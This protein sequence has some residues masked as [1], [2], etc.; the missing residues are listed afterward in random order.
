MKTVT[1][2]IEPTDEH[3]RVL[4]A[5]QWPATYKEYLRH[6]LNGPGNAKMTEEHIA[7]A[8]KQYAALVSYAETCNE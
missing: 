3:L 5:A 8:K 6:P 2:P 4:L 1:L 7:L